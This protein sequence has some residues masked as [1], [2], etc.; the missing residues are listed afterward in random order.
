MANKNPSPSTRFGAGQKQ[1]RP[2]ESRDRLSRAFLYELAADFEANGKV[3]IVTVRETDPAAYLRV[4]ASLQP[5]ELEITRPEDALSDDQ[6]A[7]LI[8]ALKE[9]ISGRAARLAKK[10]DQPK[11]H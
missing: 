5:K 1:G 9:D 3:A 7:S 10:T 2:R 6:L 4:V 11:V 8:E